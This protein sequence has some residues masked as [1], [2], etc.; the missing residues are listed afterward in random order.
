ML[1]SRTQ[2]DHDSS[3][4]TARAPWLRR[5]HWVEATLAPS[6]AASSPGPTP[7]GAVD[8]TVMVNDLEAV[9]FPWVEHRADDRTA[10]G[11]LGLPPVSS[12]EVR[13]GRRALPMS[14][15][16]GLN[17]I[18]RPFARRPKDG[19]LADD[20]NESA[21]DRLLGQP[22]A[23]KGDESLS[24]PVARSVGAS[25]TESSPNAPEFLA[26][27]YSDP[28]HPG[29]LRYWDGVRWTDSVAPGDPAGYSLDDPAVATQVVD[30]G[31]IVAGLYV[32]PSV[33]APGPQWS[34]EAVVTNES[35]GWRADPSGLHDGRY[36]E[37]GQPTRRVRDGSRFYFEAVSQVAPSGGAEAAEVPG[38]PA[39]GP[40]VGASVRELPPPLLLQ[41][42]PPPQA[43]ARVEEAPVGEWA[44]DP[45]TLGDTWVERATT[46]VAR[47]QAVDTSET[48]RD[49]VQAAVVVS[50]MAQTLL[51][52]AEAKEKA[53]QLIRASD[54]AA[55]SASKAKQVADLCSVAAREAGDA[56][57]AVA[58]A[59]TD[60]KREAERTARI[61]AHEVEAAR[62]AGESASAARKNMEELE[63]IVEQAR[64]V[65]T[66]EAWSTAFRLVGSYVVGGAQRDPHPR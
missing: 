63:S 45:M 41:R 14:V 54:A 21:P 42:L 16:R 6:V 46:A 29:S 55:E 3:E 53:Q 58:Q 13:R 4:L 8:R 2:A 34:E 65:D 28:N 5:V 49:A 48:W 40:Q 44:G 56:A 23:P 10:V 50:E 20:A 32:P 35:S 1:A 51:A 19:V 62:V 27:W 30:V 36:F 31:G 60:A 59:A 9:T 37:H 33:Q 12:N 43:L 24:P 17:F 7:V 39:G 47:A 25:T 15:S 18:I 52:A 22:V 57:R 64:E 26:G 61:V 38:D 66:P 11:L